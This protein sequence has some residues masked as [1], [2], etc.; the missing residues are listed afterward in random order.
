MFTASTV[1][2]SNLLHIGGIFPIAGKGGW[3]GGQGNL[4]LTKYLLSCGWKN[5]NFT[6]INN[7]FAI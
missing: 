4:I 1:D 2:G 5:G 7:F 6:H 3:Q